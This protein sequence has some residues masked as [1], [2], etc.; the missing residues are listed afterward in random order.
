MI[1]AYVCMESV[2]YSLYTWMTFLMV[3]TSV[4]KQS[5]PYNKAPLARL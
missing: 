2:V 5:D 4:K 1:P 3:S